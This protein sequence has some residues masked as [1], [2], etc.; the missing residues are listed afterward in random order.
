[1]GA[2]FNI[3][4]LFRNLGRDPMA[5]RPKHKFGFLDPLKSAL[6]AGAMSENEATA[7]ADPNHFKLIKLDEPVQVLAGFESAPL[8]DAIETL[9]YR[10]DRAEQPCGIE[11]FAAMLLRE[12]DLPRLRSIAAKAEPQLAFIDRSRTFYLNFD[13]SL[14]ELD[15]VDDL[16][17]V[18]ARLN[19]ILYVLERIGAGLDP[20][21]SSPSLEDCSRIEQLGLNGVTRLVAETLGRATDDNPWRCPGT[22]EC[23]PGGEWDVRTRLAHAV[24]S[25]NLITR[26]DY[27]Y[28][29]NVA[30]GTMLV[31]FGRSRAGVMPRR[32]YLCSSDAWRGVD[33][34]ERDA[35]VA[36][37]DAR[38]A[39]VLA[40]ACFAAGTGIKRAYIQACKP[41]PDKGE[42]LLVT[43]AFDR[44]EFMAEC[45][46]VAQKA[47]VAPLSQAVC[48]KVL[49]AHE[50][51]PPMRVAPDDAELRPRE[52]PRTLPPAL[53]DLLLADTAAELEVMEEDGDPYTARIVELRE[54]LAT[55]RQGAY[56]GLVSLVSEL[57]AKCTV[58]ELM[59]SG[60][61]QTQFC[62]N[63]LVRLALP[64]M[65]EDRRVRI[66][67][68]PDALYFAQYEIV[69][70]YAEAG[71]YE[72]ALPEARKLYD[73]ARSS[74][75]SHFVLINV[76][77]HL[78]R[79]EEIVE[80]ARH[81]LR[82]ACDRESIGY[83]FYRLAFAYW[84][85]DRR[86]LALACYRLVPK[87]D[88]SGRNATEEMQGLMNEMG[89]T[90]PPSFKDAV[91]EIGR[92]GLELPPT[93]AVGNQ[94][95]DAA[96]Q[97]VD[98]G[99]FFLAIRC[100]YQ[101]WRTMGNDELGALN[102]SLG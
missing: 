24:E 79:F 3:G 94:I 55:D 101:M 61:V 12:V 99:F 71:D 74:M 50:A 42:K 28:R 84:N 54:Q 98:N 53:R 44:V 39:L 37:H 45:A 19:R 30:E 7:D 60:P 59:A 78:E 70:L 58:A 72:A 56:E 83:L 25:L 97:L 89:V 34:R 92:A 17:A 76:L 33:E 67:R 20:A 80:V 29:A 48:G 43:Y 68:A 41:D 57:E 88:T 32:V 10:A 4:A 93:V 38:I 36:E 9:L 21:S 1:M 100:I 62:E 87:G 95:A 15:E 51:E 82:I 46:Q 63:Q 102:R 96:V 47:A 66:L 69:N 13:R 73:L 49:D 90:E 22:V 35:W 14:L 6:G 11:R 86:E 81:G 52:D 64:V 23:K 75:Q 91:A 85:C 2:F 77:A 31:R 40:A 8:C 27:S 18:E 65:E 5:E 16:L 26:L